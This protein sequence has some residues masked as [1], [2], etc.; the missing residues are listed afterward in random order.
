MRNLKF[1]GLMVA[2]FLMIGVKAQAETIGFA[3]FKKIEAGYDYAV[4]SY[5]EID[6]KIL[7]LQQFII[8]KDKEYKALD[9]PIAKK[10]FEEKTQKDYKIKEDSVLKAKLTKEDEIFND[11]MEATKI[12]AEQKKIDLVLDYRVIFTGGVDLSDDI[13]AYLNKN[14]NLSKKKKK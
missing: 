1:F 5:K 4:N 12:V 14:P 9:S 13:T 3:N 6:T 11:I 8:N 2:V 10:N 7:E